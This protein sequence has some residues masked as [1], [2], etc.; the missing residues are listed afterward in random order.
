MKEKQPGFLLEKDYG[1]AANEHVLLL[2]AAI[3]KD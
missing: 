2:K 1:S 3:N